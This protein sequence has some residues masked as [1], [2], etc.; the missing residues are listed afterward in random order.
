MT[1]IEGI[2][3]PADPALDLIAECGFLRVDKAQLTAE[4]AAVKAE[5]TNAVL[6]LEDV[7]E[8]LEEATDFCEK[9]LAAEQS[10]RLVERWRRLLEAAQ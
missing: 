3:L 7:S 1:T 4:L 9:H 2:D 8:G 6:M 5:L 10:E